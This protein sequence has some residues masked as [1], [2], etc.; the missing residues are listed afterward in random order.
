LSTVSNTGSYDSFDDEFIGR[1]ILEMEIT[2]IFVK[3]KSFDEV[4]GI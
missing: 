2:D 4:P 3:K 1:G